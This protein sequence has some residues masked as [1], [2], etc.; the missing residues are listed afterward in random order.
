[1]NSSSTN[2]I[3]KKVWDFIDRWNIPE[4]TPK[5]MQ[6]V[7]EK[8]IKFLTGPEKQPWSSG[9]GWCPVSRTQAFREEKLMIQ[10]FLRYSEKHTPAGDLYVETNY[11]NLINKTKAPLELAKQYANLS[12]YDVTELGL[13]PKS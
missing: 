8:V 10:G 12:G 9:F 4:N 5:E 2:T 3:E 11:S 13:K 6:E 1:M 7:A